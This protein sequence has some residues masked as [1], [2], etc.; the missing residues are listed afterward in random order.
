MTDDPL[1]L[2]VTRL[3]AALDDLE[4]ALKT[5]YRVAVEV[6]MGDWLLGYGR[7]RGLWGL[8]VVNEGQDQRVPLTEASRQR[9]VGAC[10]CLSLLQHA[11]DEASSTQ[12]ND[13]KRAVEQAREFTQKVMRDD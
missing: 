5:K 4:L 9:R 8:Y 11:L 12:L 10:A 3:N 2:E 13:L 6:P 7:V 1:D